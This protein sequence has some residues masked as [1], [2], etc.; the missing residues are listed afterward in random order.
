M[1]YTIKYHTTT[2]ANMSTDWIGPRLYQAKLEEV[3]RGALGADARRRALHQRF[4]LSHAGR[5]RRL[6]RAV[7]GEDRRCGWTTS[8][9]ASIR[10]ARSCASR[11]GRDA[12]Y[13]ESGLVGPAARS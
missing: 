5:L 8:S 4:P 10:G 1:E 6:S 12:E 11:T 3:L 7:H 2:A 9:C 13:A